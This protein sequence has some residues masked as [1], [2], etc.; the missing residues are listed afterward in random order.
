MGLQ[1]AVQLPIPSTFGQTTN[2][3]TSVMDNWVMLY[4]NA[5]TAVLR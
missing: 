5:D 1:L 2:V 4:L 3:W